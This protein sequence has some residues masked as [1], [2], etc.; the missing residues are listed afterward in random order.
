MSSLVM[1]LRGG[2]AFFLNQKTGCVVG[3]VQRLIRSFAKS[4][5]T[6]VLR[7]WRRIVFQVLA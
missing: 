5:R 7:N 6:E 1:S 3:Y 2:F 4:F